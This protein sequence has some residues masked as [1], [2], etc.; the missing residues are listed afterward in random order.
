MEK[1]KIQIV[2]L[3]M[4][5]D[6][7]ILYGGMSVE[8]PRETASLAKK[9]LGNTDRECL[10]ACAIDAKMKPTYIEIVSKEAVNYCIA[11]IPEIF[12]AALLSNAV[13][14]ILFHNHPSGDHTCSQED[15][16]I[17]ERVLEASRLLGV[18][19]LDHII[20]GEGDSFCSLR[21]T[22]SSLGWEETEW[23]Q[24]LKECRLY[25]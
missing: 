22:Y 7:D 16:I 23:K 14:L 5:K 17:T 3:Q 13:N 19:F 8:N 10:V 20:L 24:R 1:Q 15:I 12:K 9:V 11:S 6:K 4:V 2:H 21:E 25:S 18:R